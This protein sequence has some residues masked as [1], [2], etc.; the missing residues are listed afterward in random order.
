[1]Q[2]NRHYSDCNLDLIFRLENIS[3]LQNIPIIT[4]G[5][6]F[7]FN[8]FRMNTPL[9]QQQQQQQQQMVRPGVPGMP[10]MMGQ[11][12]QAPMT[13]MQGNKKIHSS[14]SDVTKS[15]PKSNSS[16]HLNPDQ[17]NRTFYYQI[18]GKPD[19]LKM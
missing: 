3:R 17:S 2:N 15:K 12:S 8:F 11:R 9:L 18:I 5:L 7:F 16:G 13:I 19:Q 10:M 1:M 4:S 6:I 14:I